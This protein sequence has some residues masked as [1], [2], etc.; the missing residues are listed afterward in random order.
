MS[1]QGQP[2]A[3]VPIEVSTVEAGNAEQFDALSSSALRLVGLTEEVTVP[4]M[5]LPWQVAQKLHAVTA[6]MTPPRT[7]DRAHDL[8]DLQ[9]VEAL[10]VDDD[11]AA[12]PLA[13][14]AVFASRAQQAWPLTI[15][16]QPHWTP[17]YSGALA[18][19]DHL[20]LAE[21]VEEAAVR[22]QQFVARIDAAQ[23]RW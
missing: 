14:I 20:D 13:G 16:A 4:C 18:G 15:I 10:L 5:T 17:I 12:T 6:A 9:L 22:V 21:T 11:L 8:V 1:Y 23:Q 7:N 3:L 19:L 2:L